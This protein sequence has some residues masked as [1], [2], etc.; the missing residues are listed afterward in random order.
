MDY[1]FSE[2]DEHGYIHSIDNFIATYY[3]ENIGVKCLDKIIDDIHVLKEKYVDIVYWEKMNMN[4]CSK[5]SF[6]QHAI[7]LD[8]GI[9]ILLG[10]YNDFDRD[11]KEMT[12][13]PM[14]RL[15]LNPNK[16]GKK[17]VFIEFMNIIETYCYDCMVN[18]Y[19]YAIDIPVTPDKVKVFGTNKE[20]GLYKGTR[21]YGQ[22][23]RNGFC[24]I[25]D[26]A[27]EQKLDK[28]LT[29]VEH[30]F[31]LT[32]TTKNISFEKI[33]IESEKAED[34]TENEKITSNDKVIIDLCNL[35]RSNGLDY[36]EILQQLNF[37][38]RC[39]I[40]EYLNSNGYNQLEFNSEIHNRLFEK[41]K[42]YFSVKNNVSADA[43]GQ[44]TIENPYEDFAKLE[45][46]EELPFD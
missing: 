30:V 37:R 29:R 34:K 32:K 39:K 1:M 42:Q 9:Y 19:D 33:Y 44:L 6:Y 11:K 8:D 28:P 3:V 5:Y 41:V 40:E 20:K 27:K 12:V 38:K 46:S 4:P 14:I 36:E 23:N 10:H 16:H 24:R 17:P 13:F 18:R 7:H 31:S 45:D 15:E 43:S 21:Y 26:K 25:Y 2:T 35:C 22:R